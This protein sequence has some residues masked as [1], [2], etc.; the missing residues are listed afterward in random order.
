MGMGFG[1]GFMLVSR[2]LLLGFSVRARVT[3]CVYMAEKVELRQ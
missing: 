2:E 3:E 1:L